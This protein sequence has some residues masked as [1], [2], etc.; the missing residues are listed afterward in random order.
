M[1]GLPACGKTDK[2]RRLT[3]NTA[4]II[5]DP[6][7]WFE[8]HQ[9]KFSHYKLTKAKRWAWLRCKTAALHH[10]TPIVMDMHVG[11]NNLSI[12]RLKDLE[13]QGY[14]VELVEPDAYYWTT[15]KALLLNKRSNREALDQWAQILAGRSKFYKYNEIRTRMNNW[16]SPDLNCWRF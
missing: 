6:H 11:I 15:I 3:A 16:Q 14:H 7:K 10:I 9:E 8:E 1:R 12:Q 13:Q 4:G 5:C 2:A